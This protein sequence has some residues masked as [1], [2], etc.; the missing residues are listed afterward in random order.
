VEFNLQ[1][2]LGSRGVIL[3][4]GYTVY[5]KLCNKLNRSRCFICALLYLGADTC[6]MLVFPP[7]PSFRYYMDL[8]QSN[9]PFEDISWQA[10]YFSLVSVQYH[11]QV[12]YACK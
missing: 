2:H 9:I 12:M 1:V 8:D 6:P 10:N 4:N 7:G 11:S 3:R 5:L